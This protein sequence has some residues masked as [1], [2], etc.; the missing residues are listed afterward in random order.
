MD[1]IQL[2]FPSLHLCLVLYLKISEYSINI[3]TL[4]AHIPQIYK[5]ISLHPSTSPN[6]MIH[7][8]WAHNGDE[9]DLPNF[10]GDWIII[11]GDR[12]IIVHTTAELY[13]QARNQTLHR[14]IDQNLSITCD[15]Y[16][17]TS[18]IWQIILITIV[19]SKT[20]YHNIWW[21]RWV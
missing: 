2:W 8:F 4:P 16:S 5:N 13:K 6:I 17:I 21:C 14:E 11:T 19:S 3:C 12:S 9:N 20:M 1:W 15:N 7:H 10:W 18:K